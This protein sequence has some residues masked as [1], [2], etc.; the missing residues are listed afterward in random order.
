VP[1]AVEIQSGPT[2]DPA[3]QAVED[4]WGVR[5][6][7]GHTPSELLEWGLGAGETAALAV[8]MERA[9]CTAVL[10]DASARACAKAFGVPMIG[11]LGVVLR[12]QRKGVIPSAAD[13][14]RALRAVGFY[15][16]DETVH[17]A[18]RRMGEEWK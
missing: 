3:R 16:D 14:L 7:P 12:A 4:G 6:T 2:S 15:L 11:T 18:L 8:A 9:P 1:V 10:E 13:V 5:V 17:T